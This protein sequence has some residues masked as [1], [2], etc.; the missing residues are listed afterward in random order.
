MRGFINKR[1][2]VQKTFFLFILRKT[3]FNSVL[4]YFIY[5]RILTDEKSR[6]KCSLGDV[7]TM[8]CMEIVLFRSTEVG[9]ILII[10]SRL[11]NFLPD[12]LQT[13]VCSK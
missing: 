9:E 1:S 8:Y 12:R 7:M 11:E 6:K 5:R 4:K 13:R 10:E 3:F 2:K